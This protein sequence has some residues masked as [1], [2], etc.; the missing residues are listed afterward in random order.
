VCRKTNE[1]KEV[2]YTGQ[3]TKTTGKTDPMKTAGTYVGQVIQAAHELVVNSKQ[4][5][6][7]GRSR[8]KACNEDQAGSCV[9][10]MYPLCIKVYVPRA[11]AIFA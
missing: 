11:C 10:P 2:L 8:V 5:H 1:H 9:I 3:R 4:V 7:L 6:V